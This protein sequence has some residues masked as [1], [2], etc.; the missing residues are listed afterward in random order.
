MRSEWGT[1]SN[2]RKYRQSIRFGIT[3]STGNRAA[4]WKC[5]APTGRGKNDI[6]LSC[7][8][9]KGALKVSLHELGEWYI[10][11]RKPKG[12]HN[13]KW[14]QQ[15]ILES[16]IT[17]V[18]KIITPSAAVTTPIDKS[19]TKKVKWIPNA[20]KGKAIEISALLTSKTTLIT[21]WPAKRSMGTKLIDSIKL[22]NEET[23]WLVYRE[24][25]IP[26]LSLPQPKIEFF[27]GKGPE[28]LR[29]EGLRVVVL[30]GQHDGTI[31]LYDS[32]IIKE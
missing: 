20:S 16:G 25:E 28:D 22:D 9:L 18:F 1:L 29:K 17:L 4:T 15:N 13:C 3:D 23:F 6:Y 21:G 26:K 5:I 19:K 31:V 8:E 24:I 10:E 7:R 27:Y 12:H 2:K 32:L 11:L 30:G 14:Q